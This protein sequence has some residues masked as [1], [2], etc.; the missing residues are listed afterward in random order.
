MLNDSAHRTNP[1]QLDLVKAKWYRMIDELREIAR[2]NEFFDRLFFNSVL[3][4]ILFNV[5]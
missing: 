5:N 1:E 4:V 3:L 2:E